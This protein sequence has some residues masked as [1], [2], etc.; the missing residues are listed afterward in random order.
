MEW[1][2]YIA[3]WQWWVLAGVLL[4]L[5][6]SAPTYFFLWLGIAAAAVGFLD[7]AFPTLSLKVEVLTF[8]A[9]SLIAV[10]AWRRYLATH[11]PDLVGRVLT[12]ESPIV[13]GAGK[14]KVDGS[15]WRVKGPDL[16]AGARVCVTGLEGVVFIVE[17]VDPA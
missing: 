11:V 1:L 13:N 16:P 4:I 5:E 17:P 8:A 2:K 15:T 7:L 12:L 6:L 14:I 3:F 10:I 9:L